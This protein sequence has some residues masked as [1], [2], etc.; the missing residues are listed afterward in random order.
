M[1]RVA[2]QLVLSILFVV[3][4]ALQGQTPVFFSGQRAVRYEESPGIYHLV[5][6]VYLK[7]DGT[8]ATLPATDTHP[9]LLW[10]AT[11]VRAKMSSAPIDPSEVVEGSMRVTEQN[12]EFLPRDPKDAGFRFQLSSSEADFN[13]HPG[14]E[15]G[16][17][18]SKSGYYQFNF[19]NICFDCATDTALP[20][21]VHPEQRDG[22]FQMFGESLTHFQAVWERIREISEQTSFEVNPKNQPSAADAEGAM[23]AYAAM[24]R[25]LAELCPETAK[26]CLRSYEKYQAC[27]TGSQT[28]VCGP[29]PACT[30]AC[31][32]SRK[33]RNDLKAGV[34]V[35]GNSLFATL[36]PDWS[37]ALLHDPAWQPAKLSS[38]EASEMLFR[39]LSLTG[40]MGLPAGMEPGTAGAPTMVALGP[41]SCSVEIGY[42]KAKLAQI[43]KIKGLIGIGAG[44][45]RGGNATDNLPLQSV[46]TVSS[47][48]RV[49]LSGLAAR[50]HLL[51]SV[52]PVPPALAVAARISGSVVLHMIVSK[53]G[54]VSEIDV[55][56][57]IDLLTTSVIEAVKQWTY[58]PYLVDGKPVEVDTSMTWNFKFAEAPAPQ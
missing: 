21:P 46:A 22:E 17:I 38:A 25:R 40:F 34:C 10:V 24:N 13:H 27:R 7:A 19:E 1:P 52:A 32:I 6:P 23:Q 29:A 4:V 11:A 41:T 20:P 49:H 58:S 56:S 39:G 43:G 37:E 44:Q 57:G 48:G 51:T 45:A 16:M 26:S 15:S 42:E 31:T 5:V 18:G 54:K 50:S 33:A 47:D 8:E 53:E 55:V 35:R 28:A 3:C 14:L 2:R 9:A 36:F 12:V 30:T